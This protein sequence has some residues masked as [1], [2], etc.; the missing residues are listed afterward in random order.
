MCSYVHERICKEC[1]QDFLCLPF[2][3]F[4]RFPFSIYIF[5]SFLISYAY[6]AELCNGIDANAADIGI[7]NPASRSVTGAFLYRTG[8]GI[9]IPVPDR[10]DVVIPAFEKRWK[11]VQYILHVQTAGS[12]KG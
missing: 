5:C 6:N 10:L 4:S 12:G 3:M 7:R 2:C 8:S 1:Q 9:D 11:D